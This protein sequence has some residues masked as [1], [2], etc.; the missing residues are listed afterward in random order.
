VFGP[1][2]IALSFPASL[3][4]TRPVSSDR[5]VVVSAG[6]RNPFVAGERLSYDVSW[7]DFLIA[8]ELTIQ[9]DERRTFDGIDGYHVTAQAKTVGLVSGLA[10]KV[11]DVYDSFINGTTLQPFRAEKHMRHGKNQAQSSVIIDQQQRIAR[12]EGGR[13]LEIPPDTYDIAGLIFAIRGMD[14][15]L[16]K[17]R[18]VTV[19]EDEKLYAIKLQ[20]ESREKIT[21]R[22]GSYDT[23]KIATSMTRGRENDKLYNLR[24]YITNDARRLPVLITAEPSWGSVRVELTSVTPAP[25][26]TK[27]DSKNKD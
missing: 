4:Q 18:N 19:I 22:T 25:S 3:S 16:G 27:I 24:M 17:A 1:I 26:Q 2:L 8:G 11:L 12:L 6:P 23:V 14:L 13:T 20:P 15:T 21:T 9:T 10:L 5:S 7:A